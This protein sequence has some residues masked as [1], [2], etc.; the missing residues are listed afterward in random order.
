MKKSINRTSR[1]EK[2]NNC[3]ENT[4]HKHCTHTTMAKLKTIDNIKC[5]QG[6]GATGALMHC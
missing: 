3:I 2:Y 4:C 1:N 5:W 6:Y